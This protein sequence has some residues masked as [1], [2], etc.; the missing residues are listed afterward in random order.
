MDFASHLVLGLETAFSFHNLLYCFF[1]VL[2]GT[3]M[4]VIPGIGTMSAMAMLFPLTFHLGRL[5]HLL[6]RGEAGF[7]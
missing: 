3:L 1:R 5:L 2:L 7:A 4:G 6:R